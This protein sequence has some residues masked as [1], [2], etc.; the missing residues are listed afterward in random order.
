MSQERVVEVWV[1]LRSLPPKEAIV[2][3][4]LKDILGYCVLMI[5][6]MRGFGVGLE[7]FWLKRRGECLDI[8]LG[9]TFYPSM[10]RRAGFGILVRHTGP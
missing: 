6:K 2:A 7:L 4:V 10:P 3:V 9:M 5:R 8:Y 1:S